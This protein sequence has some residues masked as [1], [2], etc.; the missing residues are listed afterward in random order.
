MDPLLETM[1]RYLYGTSRFAQ[2][3][4]LKLVYHMCNLLFPVDHPVTSIDDIANL[5][6]ALAA[7]CYT[8]GAVRLWVYSINLTKA[9]HYYFQHADEMLKKAKMFISKSLGENYV[10]DRYTLLHLFGDVYQVEVYIDNIYV[11]EAAGLPLDYT[12]SGKSVYFKC[13]KGNYTVS[14]AEKKQATVKDQRKMKRRTVE[15]TK[16]L[17]YRYISVETQFPIGYFKTETEYIYSHPLEDTFDQIVLRILPQK[18]TEFSIWVFGYHMAKQWEH[19][20]MESSDFIFKLPQNHNIETIYVVEAIS[21]ADAK[22]LLREFCNTNCQDQLE[23]PN[24]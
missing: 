7:K 16:Y 1:S 10:E 19:Y 20:K 5:P 9:K 11:Q 14:F 23:S 18:H 6:D 22:Q 15:A 24:Q 3:I 21:K 13:D 2:D 8:H 17:L 4:R 12:P